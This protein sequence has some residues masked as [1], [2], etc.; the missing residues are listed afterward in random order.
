MTKYVQ[1][2]ILKND[3]STDLDYLLDPFFDDYKNVAAY[4][5][6]GI[7]SANKGNDT[8]RNIFVN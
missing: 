4:Y 8:Y 2:S 7:I 6:M 1:I 3:I 5:Y